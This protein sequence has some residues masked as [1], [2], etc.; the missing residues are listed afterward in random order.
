ML[1]AIQ[2]IFCQQNL[3]LN[4]STGEIIGKLDTAPIEDT[5]FP[6]MDDFETY[7]PFTVKAYDEGSDPSRP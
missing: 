1:M 2:E 3:Q 4:N 5:A 6:E 7:E